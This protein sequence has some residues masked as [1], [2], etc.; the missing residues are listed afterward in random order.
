[1]CNLSILVLCHLNLYWFSYPF[2]LSV[3]LKGLDLSVS[4]DC[5][6][7]QNPQSVPKVALLAVIAF[8]WFCSL[9]CRTNMI[10]Q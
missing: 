9:Q 7:R 2:S 3:G 4:L 5:R 10:R 1:M 6:W 8:L